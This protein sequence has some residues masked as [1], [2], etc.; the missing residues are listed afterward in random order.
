MPLLPEDALRLLGGYVR[1]LQQSPLEQVPCHRL[2]GWAQYADVSGLFRPRHA[3]NKFTV[4]EVTDVLAIGSPA[5]DI[6]L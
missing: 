2:A 4:H 6:D 3:W 5:E 1:A